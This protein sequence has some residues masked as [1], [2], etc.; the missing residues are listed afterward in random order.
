MSALCLFVGM[1]IGDLVLQDLGSDLI[2][3]YAKEDVIFAGDVIAMML[4]GSFDRCN[5][6]FVTPFFL[7]EIKAILHVGIKLE[8]QTDTLDIRL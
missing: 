3:L 8:P 6:L 5:V 2:H 4:P 7:T 1:M